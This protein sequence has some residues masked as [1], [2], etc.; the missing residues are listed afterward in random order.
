ML[1]YLKNKLE[2]IF[3]FKIYRNSLP[4]GVDPVD[5]I[6]KLS[7]HYGINI[8]NYFDVGANIGQ[9]IISFKKRFPDLRVQCFEPIAK[10]FKILKT[11]TIS[12]NSIEYH[13]FALGSS[14]EIIKVHA[15][16]R[17]DLFSLVEPSEV[18]PLEMISVRTLDEVMDE[19]NEKQIDILKIDTEGYDL[20]VL[21]GAEKILSLGAVEFIQVETKLNGN[22]K[23]F[24]HLNEF[25]DYLIPLGYDLMSIC[26]QEGWHI[27]GPLI[28]CNALFQKNRDWYA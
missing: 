1:N 2:D 6:Y 5:E 14:S 21:K 16:E 10:T 12:L 24:I 11:N 7:D 17:N 18:G 3:N 26:N 19:I 28:F 4:K 15:G 27:R 22:E 25:T 9:N 23:R 20:E 13:Q 8:N